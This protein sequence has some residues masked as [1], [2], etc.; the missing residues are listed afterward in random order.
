MGHWAAKLLTGCEQVW[1]IPLAHHPP[2][3]DHIPR[4]IVSAP[5]NSGGRMA[6]KASSIGPFALTIIEDAKID[7]LYDLL[8]L[9]ENDTEPNFGLPDEIPAS[10]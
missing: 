4:I 2:E 9:R 8:V 6:R 10:R 7:L 5:L 1:N 3:G